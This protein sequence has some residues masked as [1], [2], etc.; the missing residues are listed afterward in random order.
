MLCSPCRAYAGSRA[1]IHS[2]PHIHTSPCRWAQVQALSLVGDYV[3]VPV[4]AV[5]R[6]TALLGKEQHGMAWVHGIKSDSIGGSIEWVD[7]M[8]RGHSTYISAIH[9]TSIFGQEHRKSI[10]RKMV[11]VLFAIQWHAFVSFPS[12]FPSAFVR[13]FVVCS[14][15][16]DRPAVRVGGDTS[17]IPRA[18]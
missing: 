15:S 8:G 4:T 7:G 18:L 14:R 5:L 12:P 13:S 2:T 17:S 6:S 9:R 10:P 3:Y 16:P 1:S 11:Y